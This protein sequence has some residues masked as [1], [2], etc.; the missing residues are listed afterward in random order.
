MTAPAAPP[1]ATTFSAGSLFLGLVLLVVAHLVVAGGAYGAAKLA[2]PT[3]AGED[4]M[5]AFLAVSVLGELAVA[6]AGLIAFIVL[7]VKRR[8]DWALGV[9]L[10]WAAGPAF[11]ALVALVQADSSY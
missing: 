9:F 4:D 7:L 10:G 6:G 5:A 8:W 3:G 1:R 2:S 11:L